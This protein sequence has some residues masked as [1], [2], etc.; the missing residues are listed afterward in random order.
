MAEDP[1]HVPAYWVQGVARRL[2]EDDPVVLSALEDAGLDRDAVFGAQTS[3][4]YR[5]ELE[6]LDAAAR[7][8]GRDLFGVE[9]GI[10]MDPRRTSLLS[11]LLLNSVNLGDGIRNVERYLRLVRGAANTTL[12]KQDDRVALVIENEDPLVNRNR[13]HAEFVMGATL[14]A[15]RIATG[16]TLRPVE[17]RFIHDRRSHEGGVARV[18]GGPVSFCC[19]RLELV[20]QP[21]A[22]LLELVEADV[23]LLSIL[24]E[25]AERQLA[26]S[27]RLRPAL[28]HRVERALLE[29]LNHEPPSADAIAS[30]LGLSLRTLTRRLAAEGCTYRQVTDELR[31][32]L[33]ESYLAEPAISLAEVALL[34]GYADQSSFTTA[35]KRWTNV[36]PREHRRLVSA[37]IAP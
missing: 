34:L 22:L 31:Q 10:A 13:H 11:Y 30:E 9:L 19:P 21:E 7:H 5:Q 2:G 12:E 8:S 15:F 3:I 33:A 16:T 1:D 17:V 18:L 23:T 32:R 35:F 36:T 26:E 28:R 24:L 37:Q 27:Q 29:R 14:A 4:T 25:H 20:L 6:F